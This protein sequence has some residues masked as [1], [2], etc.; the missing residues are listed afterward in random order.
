M[1]YYHLEK[2]IIIG[3][4]IAGLSA[5]NALIDKDIVPLV[6]EG[7]TIGSPKMCG[8]F[9][10]PS[11]TLQLKQ[12]EIEPP[13]KINTANFMH[14]SQTLAIHFPNAAS[15]FARQKAEVALAERLLRSGGVIRENNRIK[16]I[17]PKTKTMPFRILLE[18]DEEFQASSIIIATGK[19][20]LPSASLPSFPYIGIKFHFPKIIAQHTLLM[21]S[22]AQAYLGI[23]PISETESNC[24]CLIRNKAYTV[25]ML[26]LPFL[27]NLFPEHPHL[28]NSLRE[29]TLTPSDSLVQMA[30]E[31]GLKKNPDWPDAYWIG[32]AIASIHPAIG[33]GFAHSMSTGISAAHHLATSSAK[34]YAKSSES[35]A[36][37]LLRYSAMMHRLLLSTLLGGVGMKLLTKFP[38]LIPILLHKIQF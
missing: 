36:K 31:F 27:I 14:C 23:V 2:V 28:Q 18:N 37:K 25:D 7:G 8:E 35:E 21:F 20:F 19:R 6:L 12:W 5:A 11:A 29:L 24:T 15:G 33:S 9:V 30:P 3:A 32:D 16:Q 1:E 4:G 34:A 17:I 13:Q 26:T 22:N 10:A 38:S